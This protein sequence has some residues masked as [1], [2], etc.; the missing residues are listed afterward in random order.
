[1]AL[2]TNLVAYWKMDE[3]SGDATDSVAS[4]TLTNTNVTYGTG[5]INNGAAFN[6][7]GDSLR[8]TTDTDFNFAV[9]QAFTISAWVNVASVGGNQFIFSHQI[10][11]A[12]ARGYAL[13]LTAA[14]FE[15]KVWDDVGGGK[16]FGTYTNADVIAINTWYHLTAVYSG[17]SA[18][19]GIDLYKNGVLMTSTD[20]TAGTVATITNT[21]GVT[22][23][24]T[25]SGATAYN[26]DGTIDEVGVWNR[27]LSADEVSQLYNSNRALAYPL[28][29]PTLY[30]GVAYLKLDDASGNPVDSIGARTFTNNNTV[31]FSAGKINNG[32][33]FV[34]ASSRDIT[35]PT[36][37]PD[38]NSNT[39]F[40]FSFWMKTTAAATA[41]LST[42]CNTSAHAQ[43]NIMYYYTSSNKKVLFEI[44]P[45]NSAGN[46]M[47]VANTTGNDLHDGTW[48]HIAITYSGS[49]LLSGVKIYTDG[50]S[51]TVVDDSTNTLSTNAPTGTAGA[52]GSRTATFGSYLTG[53]LDEFGIFNRELTSTEV[54][55]LYNAGAGL[56]Y[57]WAVSTANTTNFFNFI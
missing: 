12:T 15:M 3:S 44:S 55:T 2:D 54:S 7:T 30:G 27:A 40:S 42:R 18:A 16:Y 56:Q 6:S 31:G 13:Q 57:P 34:A 1:M 32:A 4:H 25:N 26:F 11:N 20:Y 50:T 39:P 5:K 21:G 33:D 47:S 53:S 36:T 19:T 46:R 41:F 48:H 43:W 22:V 17:N 35:I 37:L 28:T 23:G 38:L 8:T 24:N 14:D 52:I 10:G 49:R 9:N 45:A 29:A 51:Q